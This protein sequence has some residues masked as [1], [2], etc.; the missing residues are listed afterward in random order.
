VTK[1]VQEAQRGTSDLDLALSAVLLG[2]DALSGI[3]FPVSYI[4]FLRHCMEPT[5]HR[6]TLVKAESNSADTPAKRFEMLVSQLQES[7][8]AIEYPVAREIAL[9]ADQNRSLPEPVEIKAWQWVGDA[10]LHFSSSSSLGSKGRILFNVIRL[11][12][13]ER[14]LELGTAYGMSALFILAGLKAYARS[15]LLAT[16]EGWDQLFSLSSAM[17]KQ[18]YGE[19]VSCHLGSTS[20][21]LPQL[22]QSLGR[23]DFMFHDA[24]HSREDY[25]NDFKQVVESLAPGAVVLFDDIRWNVPK[26]ARNLHTYEGWQAVVAH[27]RVRRAIEIDGSLGLLLM[28]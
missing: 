7:L 22:V 14:C 11:M 8:P 19:M 13:S 24:G 5:S 3:R 26:V 21:V 6:V 12:R 1:D 10:G 18:R 23:I 25:I 16:V 28:A 20:S 4:E 2:P 9:I 15:G 27:P 17:L